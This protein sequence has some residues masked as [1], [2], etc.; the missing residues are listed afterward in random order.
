MKTY[1]ITGISGYIGRMIAERILADA[2]ED[3]NVIGISRHPNKAKEYLEGKSDISRLACIRWDLTESERPKKLSQILSD[4]KSGDWYIIHCAAITSSKEMSDFPVE[5]SDG[6]LKGTQ[7]MLELAREIDVKSFVF[8]SSM[9]VYGQV[10][11]IGRLRKEDEL[12]Y[13]DLSENRS[14]YPLAKRMAE[15]YCHIYNKEYGVPVKI[16]RLAQT[17]GAGVSLEDNRVFMQFA[18]AVKAGQDIVLHTS[19]ESYG[20]YCAVDEAVEAI[21]TILKKGENGNC[22]NVVNEKN[23]MT[24]FGMAGMVAREIADNNIRVV[25]DETVS[26]SMYAK[27]TRLRM[28]GEKLRTLGISPQKSLKDMYM[29]VMETI[30][31]YE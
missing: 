1:I 5:V 21:L 17:F 2:N 19:G 22:Y 27:P 30:K 8:I 29:D 26:P 31:D 12:G 24:I 7:T 25:I 15:H 20:N 16:A 10:E 9:E 6:I 11:D 18:K 23:T 3:C 4:I 28:S 13:I 14:S